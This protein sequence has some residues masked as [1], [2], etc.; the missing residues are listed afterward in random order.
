[1]PYDPD[2]V[3]GQIVDAAMKVHSVLGPGLLESTY[4]ACLAFELRQRGLHV[5]TQVPLPIIYGGHRIDLAYRLDLL[6]AGTVVVETKAVADLHPVHSAQLLSYLKLSG[7][8]VGLLL[9]FNVSRMRDGV[10]R[11]VNG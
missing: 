11:M 2:I 3:S 7:V 9:N 5:M 10:R 1:M 6:V 8:K 4:T